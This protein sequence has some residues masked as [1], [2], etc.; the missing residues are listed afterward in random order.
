MGFRPLAGGRLPG[1]AT[2]AIAAGEV[3]ILSRWR[4]AE[5]IEQRRAPSVISRVRPGVVASELCRAVAT[6][7]LRGSA[8]QFPEEPLADSDW[9]RLLNEAKAQRMIGLLAFAV[10]EGRLPARAEQIDEI[11]EAHAHC[12]QVC[13]LLEA[14]LLA[15]TAVLEEAGVEHRVLKGPAFAHLDYADPSPRE[16]SDIDLLVRSEQYDA[17][18]AALAKVGYR[19]RYEEVRPGFD[20]RFGKGASLSGPGGREIDLHR[21]FVMG[22]FGLTIG[23]DDLWATSASFD[24]A[25]R[26]FATLDTDGRFLHACFHAAL[27]DVRVR[28]VPLHDLATMLQRTHDPVDLDRA[29]H[30]SRR[31]RSD[32]VIARAVRLAWNA[33]ALPETPFTRWAAKYRPARHD[34]RAL[35]AYLDP[36]MGY[37]ARSYAALRAVPGIRAKAAFAFALAFPGRQYGSGRHASRWTRLRAAAREVA[38]VRR[39]T[40]RY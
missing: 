5:R 1:S 36:R 20:R 17:A 40:G 3:A 14:D 34:Q 22:P 31:W 11:N 32:A 15:A 8:L 37:A 29:R 26:T 33:F 30:L 18:V 13:L 24:L 28:L 7:G 10:H 38:G 4:C 27:G 35:R 2:A 25:D 23:L 16:F 21:T 9:Q 39:G 6:T 12:M 19:R